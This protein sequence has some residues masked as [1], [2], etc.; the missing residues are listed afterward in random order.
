MI[1]LASLIMDKLNHPEPLSLHGNLSEN[2]RRWKQRFQLY[3]TAS[4]TS[5]KD[6]SVQSA[7]L[8]HVAGE[9]ALEV[10]NTFTWDNADDQ[11]KIN[12]IYEKFEAYCNPRKN[13]TYERHI[14]NTRNQQPDETIDH[15]VTDLKLKAK[16]CEFG[17]LTESLIKDRIVCGIIDDQTR[18]RLLREV[19]LTLP[20]AL[21]ICRTNE[22][23]TVHM[24]SFANTEHSTSN[25]DAIQAQRSKSKGANIHKNPCNRCGYSHDHS[26]PCPAIGQECRKCGKPNHFSRVCRSKPA[27]PQHRKPR[28]NCLEEFEGSSDEDTHTIYT[29]ADRKAGKAGWHTTIQIEKHKVSLKIDTGAQCN[30]LSLETY[31]RTSKQPLS[32]SHSKLVSFGGH[33]I[34]PCGKATLTC[35]HKNRFTVIE[36]EVVE[37]CQNLLG[38]K[39]STELGLVKRVD[40]ISEDLVANH[41]DV[42]KGLGCITGVTHRIKINP[43][44]TPVVHPPRRVPAAKRQKVREELERMEQ[45]GVIRRIQEPTEWVNS[46]VTATKKNGRL[47]ICIDPRDLNKAIKREH[48]PLPTIEEVLTRIPKASVFSVLDATSGYWQIKLDSSSEKLCTFN[49]PFGRYA[50]RRLPF[51]ISSAQDVFQAIM[52]DI[53]NDIEGTE[54][55]VD[56]LLIWAEDEEQHDIILGKVLQR[57]RERNLKF[58]KEKSQIKCSSISYIGHTLSKEG[59]KPDPTKVEAIME[60]GAPHNKEELQRFLGMITYLGKFIPTLSQTAAPLRALLVKDTEWHWGQ[61]QSKSFT[62]LKGVVSETPVLQYFDISKPTKI[63]VD[64]SSKGL[65]AALLQDD[66]PIAYASKSLTQTQQNY[67]QIEKEMLAIVFGCVRFHDYIYGLTTV[68]VE[69]DHKPLEAI[70]RKP[71]HQA[72][73]RLQK[74]MMSIQ[75]YS[76]VVKY[77]PGKELV[78]ADTLSRAPLTE[79]ATGL[80]YEE[81][82][83]DTLTNSHVH[84]VQLTRVKQATGNDPVLQAITPLIQ[85]GWPNSRSQIPLVARPYWDVRDEL[86]TQD[87]IILRGE[88]IVIPKCLQKEMLELLHSSHLGIEKC[89]QRARDAI[90]WPGMTSQIED[91]VSR[92][93]TCCKYR[94]KNTKE[95]LLPHN[96]PLRPW[97]RVGADLFELQSKKYLI[98]V[99]YYSGFIEIEVLRSTTSEKIV[100]CCKSQFARYGIP[101]SLITDNGPQFSSHT[102]STFAKQYKFQHTTSSPIYPQ[103]NGR[104]ERAVQTAKN[105]IKKAVDDNRDIYLALLDLRNT[106]INKESGSPAQRLMGRRTKTQLPTTQRLLAPKIIEPSIV[107]KQLNKEKAKQKFYYDRHTKPLPPLKAGDRV[108]VKPHDN[109]V[110]KPATVT[111]TLKEPRSYSVTTQDGQNLRRNRRHLLKCKTPSSSWA[112]DDENGPPF[113]QA[114][115]KEQGA[116]TPDPTNT[117]NAPAETNAAQ[118]SSKEPTR[119]SS[120]VTSKPD[121]YTDTWCLLP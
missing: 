15:Y 108:M 33:R 43:C 83:I 39:T 110:W 81:Y 74:M 68:E 82:D 14:F 9:D 54:A 72:P 45:L 76:L 88:R 5:E 11:N 18:S 61:E 65:G 94:R 109:S 93:Q 26:Q 47:R 41:Q 119:R 36:F 62:T 27:T 19:D 12:K 8:L 50:F 118:T 57:A 59:L 23:T 98:L 96:T 79:E 55:I 99:D 78:I 84:Q 21:E 111:A 30:V 103:S 91:M 48:Y 102:F 71:L 97:E 63:S 6:E 58:N 100:E 20:R 105:I 3:L 75:R 44:H 22:A 1:E 49:T 112:N 66:K 24:K 114:R 28:V 34:K 56:D 67:A 52:H 120:R 17:T 46:M 31:K 85:S 113:N 104:A 42:F 16:S 106:P 60:M 107:Q 70:L 13:V 37:G 92:C 101:D 89:K 53:F 4:G 29:V 32:K 35:E 10:Y 117:P 69:T 121:R 38:L 95:P 2:W 86:S 25:V 73:A 7:T 115:E 77:R 116:I 51:G 80:I 40:A 87:G 90:F 64:A